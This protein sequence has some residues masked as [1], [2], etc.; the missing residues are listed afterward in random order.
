MDIKHIKTTARQKKGRQPHASLARQDCTWAE[1][2]RASL[3]T[4]YTLAR[5]PTCHTVAK[6]QGHPYP[7]AENSHMLI[8]SKY[9]SSTNNSNEL[10]F[11]HFFPAGHS[12]TRELLQRHRTE[13]HA[14]I[15]KRLGVNLSY[16]DNMGDIV[17][18]VTKKADHHQGEWITTCDIRGRFPNARAAVT[19]YEQQRN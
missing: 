4:N 19:A 5:L 17:T 2:A 18:L 8:T 10:V 1:I 16:T 6:D 11:R 15:R 9:S 13:A 14:A 7:F 3:G 12:A